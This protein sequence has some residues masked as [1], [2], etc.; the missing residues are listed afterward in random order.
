[1]NKLFLKLFENFKE[2]CSLV[3][4]VILVSV[5]CYVMVG[6]KVLVVDKL[7]GFL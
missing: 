3:D 7:D 6:I 5:L 2:N 1:M 4:E